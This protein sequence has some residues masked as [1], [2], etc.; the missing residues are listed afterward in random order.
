MVKIDDTIGTLIKFKKKILKIEKCEMD[1]IRKS[2]CSGCF[3]VKFGGNKGRSA[4]CYRPDT[5]PI[6]CCG[7]VR[8]DGIDIVFKEV[9]KDGTALCDR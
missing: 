2:P 1:D 7:R 6:H 5:I 4:R 3:F 9:E 8:D